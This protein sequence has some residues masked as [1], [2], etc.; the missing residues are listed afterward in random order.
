MAVNGNRT[1]GWQTLN[2][3][4]K[5]GPFIYSIQGKWDAHH[6]KWI[7]AADR[8]GEYLAWMPNVMPPNVFCPWTDEY[9]EA[10]K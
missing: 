2:F 4:I 5:F 3:L 7:N 10:N 1:E 6:Q 9:K 8:D